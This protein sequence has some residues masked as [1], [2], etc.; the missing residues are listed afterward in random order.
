MVVDVTEDRNVEAGCRDG[1]TELCGLSRHKGGCKSESE[2]L[3]KDGSDASGIC[4]RAIAEIRNRECIHIL[5][6]AGNDVD[7][8][9]WVGRIE[10]YGL[11]IADDLAHGDAKFVLNQ[12]V[13]VTV[14][15]REYQRSVEFARR[16]LHPKIANG[17]HDE[18]SELARAVE[19]DVEQRGVVRLGTVCNG[20]PLHA[21]SCD[22]TGQRR[23]R[24]NLCRQDAGREI[25]HI[26]DQSG[27]IRYRSFEEVYRSGIARTRACCVR[28][29]G[30]CAI[31]RKLGRE[32]VQWSGC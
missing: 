4:I 8:L 12:F 22:E 21:L 25:A 2:R 32:T 28:H 9:D 1:G 19:C 11:H 26:E 14:A 24:C 20:K 5:A 16:S 31:R 3:R 6:D 18:L 23:I 29:H 13:R 10:H 30:T 27:C 7:A 15:D 17:T